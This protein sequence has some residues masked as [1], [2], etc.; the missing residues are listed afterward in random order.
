MINVYFPAGGF[1]TTVWLEKVQLSSV[2]QSCLLFATPW[3]AA[4]Q[5]FL[6]ITNSRSLLKLIIIM[7][8]MPSNLL[9]LCRLLLL[10]PSILSSIRV[11]SNE[12]VLRIRWPKYWSFSFRSSN[13]YSGPISFRI[14][15][16]DRL[17]VFY[18]KNHSI[19]PYARN[20]VQ[21]GMVA[22]NCELITQEQ[23]IRISNNL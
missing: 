22:Y 19:L 5:A 8:I 7:T 4:R 10:R 23:P 14:D 6:S 9:T 13:E 16:L 17:A 21:I 12:S 20:I 11:F 3:T 18:F 2:T 15:W 1:P